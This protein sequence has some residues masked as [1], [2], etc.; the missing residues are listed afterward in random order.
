MSNRNVHKPLPPVDS[1]QNICAPLHSTDNKECLHREVNTAHI[2]EVEDH[3]VHYGTG[4]KASY[5]GRNVGPH[6]F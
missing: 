1:R 6:D 4:D 3:T 2:I 5:Q